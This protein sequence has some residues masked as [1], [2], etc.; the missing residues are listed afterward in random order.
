MQKVIMI[1]M[2]LSI[3]AFGLILGCSNSKQKAAQKPATEATPIHLPLVFEATLYVLNDDGIPTGGF[4]YGLEV[5]CKGKTGQNTEQLNLKAKQ[6]V[7]VDLTE[8]SSAKVNVT[9]EHKT[10]EVMSMESIPPFTA[11]ESRFKYTNTFNSEV[12]LWFRSNKHCDEL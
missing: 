3:I 12:T 7:R 9:V 5:S 8:R 11:K 1:V 2:V 10:G 4:G 6:S